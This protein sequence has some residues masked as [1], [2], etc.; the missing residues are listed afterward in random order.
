MNARAPRGPERAVPVHWGSAGGSGKRRGPGGYCSWLGASAV[1]GV[2]RRVGT[3]SWRRRG[4]RSCRGALLWGRTCRVSKLRGEYWIPV[5]DGAPQ[6]GYSSICGRS[7]HRFFGGLT[8]ACTPRARGAVMGRPSLYAPGWSR[9]VPEVEAN[10]GFTC[11]SGS[12]QHKPCL[13]SP[14][15]A[16]LPATSVSETRRAVLAGPP[17]STLY[18][19]SR[20]R[21][22]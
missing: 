21:S 16:G 10:Y 18:Q 1:C 4:R 15:W 8:S 17:N 9:N 11:L 7:T 6:D 14:P 5:P 2:S 20:R 19:V 13:M 22:C 12:P 3:R